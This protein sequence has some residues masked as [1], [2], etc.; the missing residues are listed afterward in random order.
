MNNIKPDLWGKFLWEAMHYITMAYPDR[1]SQ[2][3]KVDMQQF[4]LSVGHIVPCEKCR[5]HYQQNLIKYPLNEHAL[6]SRYNLINWLRNIH[7]EVNVMLNKKQWSYDDVINH[8]MQPR[9]NYIEITTV[10]LLVL[11]IVIIVGYYI[12]RTK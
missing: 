7:N 6:S 8:Y 4:F 3:E 9:N 12:I 11:I 1:P 5:V 10:V 2:R